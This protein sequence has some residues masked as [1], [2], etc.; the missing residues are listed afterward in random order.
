MFQ[1]QPVLNQ[2]L[3]FFNQWLAVSGHPEID[4]I[5]DTGEIFIKTGQGFLRFFTGE[6]VDLLFAHLSY[7]PILTFFHGFDFF[8]FRNPDLVHQK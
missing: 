4:E 1:N 6:G 7:I 3:I 2:L 5:P 8:K